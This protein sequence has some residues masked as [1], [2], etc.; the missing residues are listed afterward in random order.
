MYIHIYIKG[1]IYKTMISVC[2][3]VDCTVASDKLRYH[4]ILYL[5]IIVIYIPHTQ[6]PVITFQ[7]KMEI[8]EFNKHCCLSEF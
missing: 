2:T 3:L 4:H 7:T 1:N 8:N 5:L 6:T